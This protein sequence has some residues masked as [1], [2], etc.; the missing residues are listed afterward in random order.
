MRGK[1]WNVEKI[2]SE[3][4]LE[5]GFRI[6]GEDSFKRAAKNLAR[7]QLLGLLPKVQVCIREHEDPKRAWWL[8]FEA[9]FDGLKVTTKLDNGVYAI[10]PPSKGYCRKNG[11]VEVNEVYKEELLYLFTRYIASPPSMEFFEAMFEGWM[12]N[13]PQAW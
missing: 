7:N 3:P 2:A 11:A 13:S 6:S 5:E 1:L 4:D 9:A 12:R 10:E 8:F